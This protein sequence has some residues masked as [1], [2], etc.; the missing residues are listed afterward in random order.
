QEGAVWIGTYESGLYRWNGSTFEHVATSDRQIE[1][2]VEEAD[3]SFWVGTGG[4]GL[5]R[6]RLLPIRLES[7]ASGLSLEAVRS[8]CEDSAG[9]VWAVSQNGELARR[10][11]TGWSKVAR[12]EWRELSC[13]AADKNGVVWLGTR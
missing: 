6:V 1:S 4:G 9:A 3:G 8:M 12:P 7:E 2:V 5:N 13:V 10:T 11:S